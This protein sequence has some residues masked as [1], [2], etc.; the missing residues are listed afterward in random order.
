M[1]LATPHQAA[2]DVGCLQRRAF[3]RRMGRQI[4]G[5]RD[6]DVPAFVRVPPRAELPDSSLQHLI[7]MKACIFAQHRM[8]ERGDQRAANGQA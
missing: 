8:R 7:R 5:N 3:G 2:G 1:Q 4:A 6:E